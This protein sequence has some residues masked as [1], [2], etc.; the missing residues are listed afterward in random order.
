[1]RTEL[2][3]IWQQRGSEAL[4]HLHFTSRPRWHH[5]NVSQHSQ[6][7][8]RLSQQFTPANQRAAGARW[9]G[10][11]VWECTAASAAPGITKCERWFWTVKVLVVGVSSVFVCFLRGWCRLTG[12][13]NVSKASTAVK[14]CLNHLNER[15]R[16]GSRWKEQQTLRL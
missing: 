9:G 6:S 15:G 1:M 12:S 3:L 13:W 7:D 5:S 14:L 2:G 10:G 16:D 11:K 8:G 4:S